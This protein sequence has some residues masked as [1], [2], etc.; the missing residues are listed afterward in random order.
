MKIYRVKEAS[1][2]K[3]IESP[4]ETPSGFYLKSIS[5][6]T[7]EFLQILD[8]PE[9]ELR[10]RCMSKYRDAVVIG[11]DVYNICLTCGDYYQNDTHYY[12]TGDQTDR[13]KKLLDSHFTEEV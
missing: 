13:L 12:L 11:E 6:K 9:T 7:D 10:H 5:T 4:Q 8:E 1:N 2:K 3:L